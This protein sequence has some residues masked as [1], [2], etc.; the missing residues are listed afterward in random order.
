[1]R[2]HG[3]VVIT[4]AI[5]LLS[6]LWAGPLLEK[7]TLVSTDW[8]AAHLNHPNLRIVDARPTLLSYL[9]GHIPNAIYL[10][11]ETLRLARG[12]VPAQLLPPKRLAEIFG[13]LGIGN[14][15]T[16]V[17]YSSGAEGDSF[18]HAT[19]VAFVLEWLG[20]KSVGVLDGG[21]EKWQAEGRPITQQLPQ[22]APTRFTP[23]VDTT[24]PVDATQVWQLI[25]QGKAQILDARSPQMFEKGHIPTARNAFLRDNLQGDK[26]LTWR[27]KEELLARLRALGV[28][29]EKPIIA[30]CASG[31]E[32]SQLWFTL[33]H[34]LE[35]P[36][37]HIY[38]GSWIDWTARNLPR[39]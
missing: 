3:V 36:R 9:Q 35:L 37:V 27:S 28:D 30:Y 2:R 11:T 26:W 31:R 13:A 12:G 18:A 34:V 6:T 15:H 1:M 14:Q 22:V 20:H 17:V 24:L 8:L 32:A 7:P 4:A 39:E 16:V 29:P 33:R 19:Y 23:R 10:H 21:F 5:G 25:Q 38:P